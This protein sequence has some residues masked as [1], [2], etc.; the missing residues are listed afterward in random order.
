VE[1]PAT[2]ITEPMSLL[3]SRR[4]PRLGPRAGLALVATLVCAGVVLLLVGSS[5]PSHRIRTTH[6]AHSSRRPGTGHTASTPTNQPP[7]A[8][9][10]ASN[11]PTVPTAAA[12]LTQL[13]T[14]DLGA[15]TIDQQ[16]SQQIL[17]RLQDILNS[18]GHGNPNDITHKLGDFSQQVAQLSQH[19]DIQPAALPAITTAI[20]D[21]RSALAGAAPADSNPTHPP[22]PAAATHSEPPKPPKH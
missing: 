1:G 10:P 18:Y 5:S 14:Q 7:H 21:L 22:G 8:P 6:A 3:A 20:D 17:A 15:G 4:S 9:A 12:E 16:A 11:P 13:A 19:G 2:S